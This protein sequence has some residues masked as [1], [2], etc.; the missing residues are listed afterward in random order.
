LKGL[1]LQAEPS[2][3][4]AQLDSFEVS[5]EIPKF[6]FHRNRLT[7][8]IMN[9]SRQQVLGLALAALLILLVVVLRHWWS[10]T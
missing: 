10:G 3:I 4:F 6:V 8:S 1:K 5:L 7:Y 9:G 2:A